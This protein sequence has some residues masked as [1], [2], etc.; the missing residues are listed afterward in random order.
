MRQFGKRY[1]WKDRIIIA[2]DC[3]NCKQL[4]TDYNTIAIDVVTNR[5]Y[6]GRLC[7][8]DAGLHDTQNKVLTRYDYLAE[9]HLWVLEYQE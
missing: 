8:E 5:E 2:G 3:T 4:I 9:K 7:A 1:W 6:C